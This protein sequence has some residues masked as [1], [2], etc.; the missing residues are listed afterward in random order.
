MPTKTIDD[1]RRYWNARPCNIRHSPEQVG[2]RAYFD[3]VEARKYLVEPHI[4]QFAEFARWQD[5]KVLE[6]GCGIGTDTINFARAGAH[7]TAVDLSEA[8]LAVAQRR[9]SV[10]GL[11]DRITFHQADAERLSE[12]VPVETYDLVY[13]FGVIHH[14]PQPHKAL[15]EVRKYMGPDSVLKLMVY[16]RH[17]WK[18]LW[19][20]VKYGRLAFW[21]LDELIAR[22]SE[23]QT[24]CPVTYSYSPRTARDL[25]QGFTVRRATVDHIFPYRIPEYKRYEYRKVWYF[26]MLPKGLFR[27]LEKRLGWHLCMEATLNA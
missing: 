22:Y 19:I 25:L 20:L 10:F 26:E 17:S 12:T 23:A 14:T 16:H 1:V 27:R 24:G 8:S 15:D 3:Q 18:V 7:V 2:T 13:S 6:I 4:P 5:K 21:K 9:A 11:Q